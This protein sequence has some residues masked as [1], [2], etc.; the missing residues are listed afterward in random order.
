MAN[1]FFDRVREHSETLRD[2]SDSELALLLSMGASMPAT[3][4]TR[5]VGM[6]VGDG[7]AWQA[8]KSGMARTGAGLA[9]VPNA[10]GIGDGATANKL[11]A[12]AELQ[13]AANPLAEKAS[14]SDVNNFGDFTDWL[15]FNAMQ[16][17]PEMALL[18]VPGGWVT[19][20]ARLGATAALNTGARVAG[21]RGALGRGATQL[22]PIEGAAVANRARELM[23]AA[24]PGTLTQERALQLAQAAVGGERMGLATVAA[25]GQPLSTGTMLTEQAENGQ[26]LD[27]AQAM[28][29]GIPHSI[30][31][32]VGIPGYLAR[33][34]RGPLGHT[35]KSALRR[36]GAGALEAGAVGSGQE[37]AQQGLENI[38]AGID[39]FGEEA[40]QRYLES[41][42][43]GGILSAAPGSLG[44]LRRTPTQHRMDRAWNVAGVRDV[45]R[46]LTPLQQHLGNM[47]LQQALGAMDAQSLPMGDRVTGVPLSESSALRQIPRAQQVAVQAP[48]PAAP[49]NTG[50]TIEDA[51]ESAAATALAADARREADEVAAAMNTAAQATELEV[52][53]DALNDVTERMDETDAPAVS[54]T[55]SPPVA[56]TTRD[57]EIEEA[58]NP[59]KEEILD[60]ADALSEAGKIT[61]TDVN[62]V[63]RA[64]GRGD[65]AEARRLLA[66]AQTKPGAQEAATEA[67]APDVSA[68][69]AVEDAAQDD[70][71]VSSEATRLSEKATR[72]SLLSEA[73]LSAIYNGLLPSATPAA[74][75]NARKVA[76]AA[77]DKA[78]AQIARQ[79]RIITSLPEKDKNTS[80][81]AEKHNDK[82]DEDRAVASR[83]AREARD[84]I[85]YSKFT[86]DTLRAPDMS[87]IPT[88]K[89]AIANISLQDATRKQLKSVQDKLDLMRKLIEAEETA[90]DTE[91]SKLPEREN[92]KRRKA[93]AAAKDYVVSKSKQLKLAQEDADTDP[94]FS[95]TTTP[96]RSEGA[97]SAYI[98]VVR[99]V[100]TAA[101]GEKIVN[102]LMS[103]GKLDI[104]AEPGTQ[105]ERDKHIAGKWHNGKITLFARNIAPNEALSVLAHEA[106][107]GAM[108]ELKARSLQEYNALMQ[109]L[110][111]IAEANPQWVKRAR[112]SISNLDIESDG[113]LGE[114]GLNELGAYAVQQYTDGRTRMPSVIKW[115]QDLLAFVKRTVKNALGLDTTPALN[116][117]DLADMAL[118]HLRESA[119][120]TQQEA[121]SAKVENPIPKTFDSEF[122][123]FLNGTLPVHQAISLG[124]AGPLLRMFGVPALPVEATRGILR[125]KMARHDLTGEQLREALRQV[126]TPIAVFRSK[127][128]SS[129]ILLLTEVAHKSG[130]LIVGLE[131]SRDRGRGTIFVNDVR[132]VHPKNDERLQHWVTEGNLIG[133]DKEK[134]SRFM[135]TPG[136]NFL[137]GTR[138]GASQP[139]IYSA[140]EIFK[141][142]SEPLGL[143]EFFSEYTAPANPDWRSNPKTWT[144]NYVVKHKLPLPIGNALVWTSD[145]VRAVNRWIVEKNFF[146]DALIKLAVDLGIPGAEKWGSLLRQQL[147]K[148]TEWEDKGEQMLERLEKAAG[149][150]AI[151]DKVYEFIRDATLAL[152]EAK[153]AFVKN[154]KYAWLPEDME[155]DQAFAARYNA[156][157]PAVRNAI[158]DFFNHFHENREAIG[159]A[160]KNNIDAVTEKQVASLKEELADRLAIIAADEKMTDAEK[161]KAKAA[162][163]KQTKQDITSIQREAAAQQKMFTSGMSTIHLYAPLRRVGDY[164]VIGRSQKLIDLQ[165]EL[166]DAMSAPRED[167]SEMDAEDVAEGRGIAAL[168]K[169]I[170][171]L[172]QDPAHY[173]VRG[174]DTQLQASAEERRIRGNYAKTDFFQKDKH[175]DFESD[176]SFNAFAKLA[177]NLERY[178]GNARDATVSAMRSL[179]HEMFIQSVGDTS[180]RKAELKRSNIHGLLPV[181]IRRAAASQIRANASYLATLTLGK[182]AQ[183]ALTVMKKEAK[184]AKDRAAAMSLLNELQLRHDN[185]NKSASNVASMVLSANAWITLVSKPFYYVQNATQPF[186]MTAPYLM[187]RHAVG[188]VRRE[189]LQAYRTVFGNEFNMKELKDRLGKLWQEDWVSLMPDDVKNLVEELSRRGRINLTMSLELGERMKLS[190]GKLQK[191]LKPLDDFGRRAMQRSEMVNRTVS[192]V[193]AYRLELARL[194]KDG[195]ANAEQQA[196]DYA[197]RVIADT[198]GDY[199]SFN[200]PRWMTANSIMRLATQF[201]K[202][203]MIQIAFTYKMA[204]DAFSPFREME[205][206]DR[207]AA[208]KAF[209][210]MLGTH[211]FLAGAMGLPAAQTFTWV[212]GLLLS[213][214]GAEDDDAEKQAY[215]LLSQLPGGEHAADLFMKGVPAALG[216]DWSRS[217]GAGDMLMPS[218]QRLGISS[219]SDAERSLVTLFGGAVTNR[220]LRVIDSLG[221]GDWLK[222]V[223]QVAPSFPVAGFMRARRTGSEGIT[224]GSGKNQQQWLSPEEFKWG[225]M[226]FT[227]LGFPTTK[228]NEAFEAMTRY[229]KTEDSIKGESARLKKAYAEAKKNGSGSDR[230][231]LREEWAALQNT[232]AKQ[233]KKKA[234]LSD[235]LTGRGL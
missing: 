75:Q 192:A 63:Y 109:R 205:K 88:L 96:P 104:Q 106:F 20:G 206:E 110:R 105:R 46:G 156:F 182:E 183:E 128:N 210:A 5:M 214:F 38:A 201:R 49:Q 93:I 116:Q 220:G 44:G 36:M 13:N 98:D 157:T 99:S 179:L 53:N 169:Q 35:S 134:G 56:E 225:H 142:N 42:V 31:N 37:V 186:I 27:I 151:S 4:V 26:E 6:D 30:L 177:R 123:A 187:Q 224:S 59:E 197:E 162:A 47:D 152:N 119:T 176:L 113:T 202:F 135:A 22:A 52:G 23:A 103:S 3:D 221:K 133:V 141:S 7:G 155:I 11:D 173:F 204:M 21:L 14:L 193:A 90:L 73:E 168:K 114:R 234:P 194:K 85:A 34:L 62:A 61:Q 127:S 83:R 211:M 91:G 196:I 41:G 146:T 79:E 60:L 77:I 218:F 57:S 74:Q 117:A 65:L 208:R 12:Y 126:H 195:V 89:K 8:L 112:E 32:V 92:T 45:Q 51:A 190:E 230:Q 207:A 76:V 9:R 181:D 124:R 24:K 29:L 70:L 158:D 108:M 1:P 69:E 228:E 144:E 136:A 39:L 115:A 28:A 25:V 132:S 222:A 163:E 219:R 160:I 229:Y 233:G 149:T 164:M 223:E 120:D 118:R 227:T 2:R 101:L 80:R 130:S 216:S 84:V 58:E 200:A 203:Q 125:K 174:V 235:L 71:H 50:Q 143:D 81:D 140:A 15:T 82:I 159:A 78:K 175:G 232:R 97:D 209:T 154:A 17:L 153:K 66:Y 94:N 131:A 167:T 111:G 150:S 170:D 102:R 129:T 18:A 199:S 95:E 191:I 148:R 161:A 16:S 212:A 48:P 137:G 188:D 122:D 54:E 217:V 40:M 107:H 165:D 166:A 139:I 172:K 68:D 184:K 180:A 86:L 43:L 178:S 185:F 64:T 189:M 145:R 67:H 138:T 72:S 33:G 100:L 213:A 231:A 19:R 226:L 55:T 215:E 147:E 87:L 10:V 171:K 121:P 198:Q